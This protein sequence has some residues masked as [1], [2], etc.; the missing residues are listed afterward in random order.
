MTKKTGLDNSYV[1]SGGDFKRK[2]GEPTD[3]VLPTAGES[4]RRVNESDN[5]HGEGTVD[6]V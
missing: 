6:W 4:P 3:T 5:I 2:H 1:A